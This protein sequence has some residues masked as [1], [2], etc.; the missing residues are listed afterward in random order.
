MEKVR[1]RLFESAWTLYLD[2]TGSEE[3][4]NTVEDIPHIWAKENGDTGHSG[5]DNIMPATLIEASAYKDQIG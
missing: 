5:L 1:D 3:K 4:L 2:A